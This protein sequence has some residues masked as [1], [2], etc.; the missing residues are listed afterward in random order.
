VLGSDLQRKLDELLEED[1]DLC[2]PVSL[3]LFVEPVIASDGFMYE[4]SSIEGLL[5]NRMV[6]PMTREPL[7]KEYLPAKQ[8]KSVTLA[9]R[10]ERSRDLLKFAE[11]AAGRQAPQMAAEALQ[12]ASEHLEV[13]TPA[14]VPALAKDA[15]ALWKKLGQPVPTFLDAFQPV[16]TGSANEGWFMSSMA[17]LFGAGLMC[18][19]Q[20]VDAMVIR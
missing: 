19:P 16:C 8:R 1:P 20:S 9:F 2:C 3:M 7:K 13:L 4:K 10:Q 14:Q 17:G 6:S 18:R 11:E 12:R 15:V 5:R